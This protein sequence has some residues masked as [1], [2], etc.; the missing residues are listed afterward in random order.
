[1]NKRYLISARESLRTKCSYASLIVHLTDSDLSTLEALNQLKTTKF[2]HRYYLTTS[3]V[4]SI[5]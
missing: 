1:M 5:A 3:T 4:G 2:E